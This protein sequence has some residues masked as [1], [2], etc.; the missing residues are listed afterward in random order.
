MSL[1]HK[2]QRDV[3]KEDNVLQA[4]VIADSFN[5]RFSPVTHKKPRVSVDSWLQVSDKTILKC[6]V[7][8]SPSTLKVGQRWNKILGPC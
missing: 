5:V 8:V 3:Y 1:K 4:L 7:R 2:K 6:F